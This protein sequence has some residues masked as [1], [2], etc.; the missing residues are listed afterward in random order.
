M[1]I[2]AQKGHDITIKLTEKAS[3][4]P[5]MMAT[6][7]LNPLGAYAVSDTKGN[8]VLKNIPEGSY[9]LVVSYV[10]FEPIQQQL[11]VTKPLTMQ[12]QMVET[13]LALKEVTVVAKQ[14]SWFQDN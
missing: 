13:S 10:G 6:V 7:Q 14:S 1:Q 5:I 2:L 11:K 9:T 4:E 3:K 12:L 8:A